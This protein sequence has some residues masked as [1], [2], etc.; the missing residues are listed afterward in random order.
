M[1][2]AKLFRWFPLAGKAG[3]AIVIMIAIGILVAIAV[4][5]SGKRPKSGGR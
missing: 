5:I 3:D 2:V 4:I 1:I